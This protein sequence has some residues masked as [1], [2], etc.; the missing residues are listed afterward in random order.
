MSKAVRT[1]IRGGLVVDRRGYRAEDVSIAAGVVAAITSDFEPDASDIEIDAR[2]K[3]VMPAFVDP[4]TH[5]RVPGGEEAE[6][7]ASGTRAA[8]LGG[9]AAVFAMPNTEPALDSPVRISQ[10]LNAA[11]ALPVRVLCAASITRDRAGVELAPFYGLRQVGVRVVTD[12]GSGLQD[13]HLMRRALEYCSELGIVVAQHAEVEALFRKGVMNE[14][15]LSAR[16]GVGG[17]PASAEEV[18]VA[19]DIE[20]ARAAGARIHFLHLSTARSAELVARAKAEG[21]A[22]SAEVTPH[23]LTMT[24][25]LLGGY[26]SRFKVNPPL[27]ARVDVDGL[28]EHLGLG[29]FDVIGT[30]HAPHPM[31]KKNAPLDQ[32]AFGMLGLQHSIAALWSEIPQVVARGRVAV[33]T[34]DAVRA[35]I[36]DLGSDYL[37]PEELAWLWQILSMMSWKP[38]ELIGLGS[39]FVGDI[40]PGSTANLLVFDPLA[41]REVTLGSIASKARNSP[42][43]GRTL[44]GQV[45]D[46][47]VEGRRLV[48][49]GSLIEE[50]NWI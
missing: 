43:L 41:N 5:L 32:A 7:L 46:L 35:T 23:H 14:G 37:D 3:I 25:D 10:L 11:A 12:D 38:A 42:Y 2:H 33:A 8:A 47:F 44:R 28:W 6:T 30:D 16:L 48:A 9:Y 26:D 15:Q 34:P 45:V 29:T 18:M 36:N 27:R 50:G 20:L 22:V 39:G 17:I 21:V 13:A 1:V 49:D 19:R 40:M 31:W 24:E 4:H